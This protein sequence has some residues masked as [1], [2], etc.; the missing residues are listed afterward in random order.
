M[1]DPTVVRGCQGLGSPPQD[2]QAF[3]ESK[4]P[5]R[6]SSLQVF[7]FEPLH[8]EEDFAVRPNECNGTMVD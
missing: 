5:P 3:R 7:S 1:D 2:G 8:G 4:G 6:Q